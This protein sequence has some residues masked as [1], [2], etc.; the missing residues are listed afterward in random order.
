MEQIS[1]T[2]P[3]QKWKELST[4]AKADKSPIHWWYWKESLGE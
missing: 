1:E 2:L 3:M 4:M